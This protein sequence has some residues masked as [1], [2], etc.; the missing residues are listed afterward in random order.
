MSGSSERETVCALLSDL[1]PVMFR[2]VIAAARR[3]PETLPDEILV[4]ESVVVLR[5]ELCAI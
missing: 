5:K 3:S 1:E 2:R 4:L